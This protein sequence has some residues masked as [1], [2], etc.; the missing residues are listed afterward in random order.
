MVPNFVKSGLG[1]GN[2]PFELELFTLMHCSGSGDRVLVAKGGLSCARVER[3][4]SVVFCHKPCAAA[5]RFVEVLEGN[6]GLQERGLLFA[7]RDR[8]I[9]ARLHTSPFFSCGAHRRCPGTFGS[10]GIYVVTNTMFLHFG[11]DRSFLNRRHLARF[12]LHS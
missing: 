2:L 12:H 4:I 7:E 1:P 9:V 5:A 3:A 11:V 10:C 6:R 8:W